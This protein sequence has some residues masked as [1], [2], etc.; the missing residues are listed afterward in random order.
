M[1]EEKVEFSFWKRIES[2][3]S[4]YSTGEILEPESVILGNRIFIT[5]T[6]PQEDPID[7]IEYNIGN[8]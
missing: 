1:E 7:L 5:A 6:T 2:S 3:R 4:L 8:L